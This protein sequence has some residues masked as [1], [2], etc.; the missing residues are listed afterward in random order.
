MNDPVVFVALR[1]ADQRSDVNRTGRQIFESVIARV[2]YDQSQ[3]SHRNLCALFTP[4]FQ[5]IARSDRHAG[6][7]GRGEQSNEY[8]RYTNR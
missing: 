2:N 6:S 7:G 5:H 8:K 3:R 4:H 1:F